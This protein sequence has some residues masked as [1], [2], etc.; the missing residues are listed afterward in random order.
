LPPYY[1]EEARKALYE[2]LKATAEAARTVCC[3]DE[4][5]HLDRCRLK[6]SKEALASYRA[7]SKLANEAWGL[8]CDAF[9]AHSEVPRPLPPTPDEIEAGKPRIPAWFREYA[10]PRDGKG[11]DPLPSITGSQEVDD[12]LRGLENP[13]ANL[14]VAAFRFRPT[15]RGTSQRRTTNEPS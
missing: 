9:D 15:P 7:L 4:T 14:S 2:A 3:L 11:K 8:A 6:V 12:F 1:Y 10:G 13:P 5:V